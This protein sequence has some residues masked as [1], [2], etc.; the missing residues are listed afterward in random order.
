MKKEINSFILWL[1]AWQ[2][3]SM[4]NKTKEQSMGALQ[5]ARINNV[6]SIVNLFIFIFYASTHQKY[7]DASFSNYKK[8]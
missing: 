8:H 7:E 6:R 2:P 4:H 3:A 5:S 1:V